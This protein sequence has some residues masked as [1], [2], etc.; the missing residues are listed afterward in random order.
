MRKNFILLLSM[1]VL[2][3]CST[4]Q[5]GNFLKPTQKTGSIGQKIADDAVHRIATLY[6]PAKTSLAFEQPTPDAFG[7]ALIK[8]LR[9]KGYSVGEFVPPKKAFGGKVRQSTPQGLPVHYILDKSKAGMYRLAV[10]IGKQAVSRPYT[11]KDGGVVPAGPW[12]R[13]E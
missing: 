7:I 5:Y 12:A 11:V 8:G 4:A 10:M 13:E 3:A 1:L 6:P 2:S 9:D